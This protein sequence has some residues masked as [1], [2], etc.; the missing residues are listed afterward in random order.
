VATTDRLFQAV[1]SGGVTGGIVRHLIVP[2]ILPAATR[3]EAGR[4]TIFRLLSQTRIAY[5]DSRLSHGRA[6]GIEAGERLPWIPN[7]AN[8]EPLRSCAWQVHMHGQAEA[9]FAANLE[10]A[11]LPFRIFEYSKAAED[12]GY[13]DGAAYLVRPDAY[14]AVAQPQ[15]D[16]AALIDYLGDLQITLPQRLNN[17]RGRGMKPRA[18]RS[19]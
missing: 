7:C 14:V 13:A 3:F 4:N 1:V 16:A 2:H 10:R 11:G 18:P 12:A 9:A 8:F 15:P 5:K 17:D 19:A 6:G